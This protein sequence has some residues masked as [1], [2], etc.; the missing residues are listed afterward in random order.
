M[1]ILD[2]NQVSW[3]FPLHCQCRLNAYNRLEM[4]KASG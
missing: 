2:S 1:A 3:L 4:L